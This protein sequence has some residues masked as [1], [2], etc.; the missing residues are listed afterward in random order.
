M[1]C[2][3][4]GMT[5]SQKLRI[6][7]KERDM[8]QAAVK[9]AVGDVSKDTVNRWFRGQAT[10]DIREGVVI[11]R[12]LGVPLDYLADDELDEPPRAE[13]S[14]DERALIDLYHAL[15]LTKFEALRRLAGSPPIREHT[16]EET[17]D[18]AKVEVIEP[19][20]RG[21]SKPVQPPR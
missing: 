8:K 6:L 11:A 2:I 12:L 15:K 10:P 21:R 16:G 5:F 19:T 13:T 18:Q 20:S 17:T 14:E 4:W 3:I 1:K 9:R 7:C